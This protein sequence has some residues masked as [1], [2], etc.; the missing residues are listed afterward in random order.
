AASVLDVDYDAFVLNIFCKFFGM[1]G[2]L[3]GWLVAADDAVADLENL[4]QYLF[5][6]APWM[7]QYA[8][9]ACFEPQTLAFLEERRGE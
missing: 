2:W 9:L 4:A 1:T 8:A 7:A 3:L 5:I 6:S